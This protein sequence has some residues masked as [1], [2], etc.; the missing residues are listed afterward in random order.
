MPA[1]LSQ[2]IAYC[3]ERAR[4]YGEKAR[5]APDLSG[6]QRDFSELEAQW[7][8]LAREYKEQTSSNLER[9]LGNDPKHLR[10]PRSDSAPRRLPSASKG[11]AS[12]RTGMRGGPRLF[13]QLA[14]NRDRARPAPSLAR[15]GW[16]E[17]PDPDSARED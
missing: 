7:L 3:L 17:R 10:Q 1:R 12:G 15:L 8:S 5:A 13:N 2:R 11:V 6:D 16:L 9:S 14:E 4:V